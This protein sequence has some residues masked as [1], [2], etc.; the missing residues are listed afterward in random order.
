MRRG[1]LALLLVLAACSTGAE[2]EVARMNQ[3]TAV[4][5]AD[6]AA[7]S[8]RAEASA[9][10]RALKSRLPPTDG[11]LTGD[12]SGLSSRDVSQVTKIAR[13][14]IIKNLE[15]TRKPMI[16]ICSK[17]GGRTSGCHGRRARLALQP[18]RE[19]LL[20][21]CC[22]CSHRQ[23][24]VQFMVVVSGNR[25]RR[26]VADFPGEKIEILLDP[27]GVC[28]KMVTRKWANMAHFPVRYDRV[29][30]VIASCP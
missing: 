4:A 14:K 12:T 6:M 17:Q 7:C 15:I 26:P 16:A 1:A 5:L 8:A 9:P 13:Q 28:P 19:L 22:R 27:R 25:R 23:Q 10:F 2:R 29:A 24:L 11:S 21:I 20:Q 3:A 30:E 18:I